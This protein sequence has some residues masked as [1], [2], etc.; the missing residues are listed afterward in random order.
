MLSTLQLLIAPF[1]F[2]LTSMYLSKRISCK[3]G[4]YKPSICLTLTLCFCDNQ[5]DAKHGVL[6]TLMY[7][8]L[9]LVAPSKTGSYSVCFQTQFIKTG[10][11]KAP[12]ML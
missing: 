7:A 6:S 11:G 1:M 10:S 4:T 3:Y 12:S 9:V 8:D 5:F 2:R